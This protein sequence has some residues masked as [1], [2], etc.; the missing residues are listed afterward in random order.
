[1]KMFAFALVA[2]ITLTGCSQSVSPVNLPSSIKVGS[3]TDAP[4][5]TVS[6]QENVEFTDSE[7]A[8]ETDASESA[9]DS[10]SGSVQGV[11]DYVIDYAELEIEDQVGDGT[12]VAIDEVSTS[13]ASA[14]IVISNRSGSVLGVGKASANST[15]VSIVLSTPVTT[16]QEL[17]AQLFSD[18]G[19]GGYDSSDL[20]VFESL[21]DREPI[22]EDFEYVVR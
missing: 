1:M 2:V 6:P 17:Y 22:I 5:D 21:E 19:N 8:V 18:N 10:Q 16:S 13:L 14:L 9:D 20:V 12:I 4:V 15:P 7:S 11:E 3:S